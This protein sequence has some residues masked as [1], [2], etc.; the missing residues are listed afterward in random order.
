VLPSHN[1]ADPVNIRNAT[2]A[3]RCCARTQSGTAGRAAVWLPN[4]QTPDQAG[5][6]AQRHRSTPTARGRIV[7]TC[8]LP[9]P[10]SE[11]CAADSRNHSPCASSSVN[12]LHHPHWAV[13]AA[14][15]SLIFEDGRESSTSSDDAGLSLPLGTFWTSETHRGASHRRRRSSIS[16]VICRTAVCI[17]ITVTSRSDAR[18][19][20]PAC[21]TRYVAPILRQKLRG[22][23]DLRRRCHQVQPHVVGLGFEFVSRRIGS[24]GNLV[25]PIVASKSLTSFPDFA[26]KCFIRLWPGHA[27]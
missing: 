17:A 7:F 1:S 11:S 6:T 12:T 9:V 13:Q 20:T 16:R 10:I 21:S 24:S 19:Q 15:A 5:S 22:A 27:K 25:N 23:I 14:R 8:G 3:T 2:R 26:A 4:R 18:L